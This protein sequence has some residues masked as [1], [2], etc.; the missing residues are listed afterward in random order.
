MLK[1]ILF[2]VVPM[3]LVAGSVF[4]E[5]DLL[6][7]LANENADSIAA[8]DAD[9]DPEMGKADVD[10]LLGDKE[11]SEEEAI[12]A[13]YRRM[14]YGSSYGYSSYS[15]PSYNYSTYHYPT[16]KYYSYPTV[17]YHAPVVYRPVHYTYYTPVYTSYWGCH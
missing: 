8:V 3:V 9:D 7:Q 16:Y 6:T 1:R 10:A 14:S 2:A 13:C 4:A 5:D 15:Y 17:T 12:A 11:E